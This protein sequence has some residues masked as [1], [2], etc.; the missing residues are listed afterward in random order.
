MG[1]GGGLA[2]NNL[3]RRWS[4]CAPFRWL[5]KAALDARLTLP[6][7]GTP[8][9]VPWPARPVGARPETLADSAAAWLTESPAAWPVIPFW[10]LLH[11]FAET[12]AESLDE[13]V[14]GRVPGA[15]ADRAACDALVRGYCA[16]LLPF[17]QHVVTRVVAAEI[18][19]ERAEL[20]TGLM[21]TVVGRFG[22]R[23]RCEEFLS[24]YRPLH[25]QVEHVLGA[26]NRSIAALIGHFRDDQAVIRH[27]LGGSPAELT[28]LVPTGDL[29]ER[30]AVTELGF[31][32][33][34]GL[35]HKPHSLALDERLTT[36]FEE[37]ARAE[38]DCAPR[39]PPT[40]DRDGYGWQRRV[41]WQ[42]VDSTEQAA[43][44][45]R[46]I[47]AMIALAY[48][49]RATD[50]H[51]ENVLCQGG[52]LFLLDTECFFGNTFSTMADGRY[53]AD[54]LRATVLAAC[55]LPQ[56]MRRPRLDRTG[57]DRAV[58]PSVLGWHDSSQAP[59][60][61]GSQRS[62]DQPYRPKLGDEWLTVRGHETAV[63]EGF[64]R[65]YR[66]LRHSRD[67][68]LAPDGPLTG[69]ADVRARHVVRG[70]SSYFH[71]LY[72]LGDLSVA[73]DPHAQ[74]ELVNTL[75]PLDGHD[76]E[77]S[78]RV[79]EHE[80]D[81]LL[82]GL[83]PTFT[84]T[85]GDRA[86]CLHRRIEDGDGEIRVANAYPVTSID[87]VRQRLT[88]LSEEDLV[89]Q[90]RLIR[91]ALDLAADDRGAA[92]RDRGYRPVL[93][94]AGPDHAELLAA[95]RGIAE[96]ISAGTVH[97][98]GQVW[99]P[100]C[101]DVGD[102]RR[103]LLPST[104]V[105]YH[106]AAGIALFAGFLDVLSGNR[107]AL[108]EQAERAMLDWADRLLDRFTAAQLARHAQLSVFEGIWGAIYAAACLGAARGDEALI[109][110][111]EHAVRATTEGI[112][113][114]TGWDVISGSAGIAAVASEL[115]GRLGMPGSREA[116]VCAL[117]VTGR[118][119][120]PVLEH[121]RI[122][123]GVAHGLSGAAMAFAR[124]AGAGLDPAGEDYRAVAELV[125]RAEQ[126]TF[127][128][129]HS[130]WPDSLGPDDADWQAGKREGWC[131]G[132]TGIG[133]V[134]TELADPPGIDV[135]HRLA[136]AR[137]L[138][139]H[140]AMG[141]E[142]GLCHGA[143]GAWELLSTLGAAET[144][145]ALGAILASGRT[146]GWVT[147]VAEGLPD[148]GLMTGLAGIGLGL[149]RAAEPD[150]TPRVLTL[151]LPNRSA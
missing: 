140:R 100:I 102:K 56:P 36:V 16:G 119:L 134:L 115:H 45:F 30:G 31:A 13:L 136:V 55:V 48:A 133:M 148:F 132:A 98:G 5:P 42:P 44:Y 38:P 20:D 25:R 93:V 106:G 59:G 43:G 72:R 76:D 116:A 66:W 26:H 120:E 144:G 14:R 22:E 80:R 1:G 65:T 146:T 108:A 32:D 101:A 130:G 47:G 57:A 49:L 17:V 86:L 117:A 105:L 110:W 67:R 2:V 84:L 123:T 145:P 52:E 75:W 121:Q 41:A 111:A 147:G 109:G 150:R 29:H 21:R 60:P 12:A 50:L 63:I 127:L 39:I 9:V 19:G 141:T 131:R 62:T 53:E 112:G 113:E 96:L 61:A 126:S 135:A 68:L 4:E 78:R 94:A 35:M 83:I 73:V 51:R 90:C 71:F 64:R 8:D 54:G 114:L 7:E 87:L 81:G 85:V 89:V 143:F 24:R 77:A 92:R 139:L 11:H 88:R 137:E 10:P 40:V 74:E 46:R 15:P 28:R 37:F 6:V 129:E 151:E 125:M 138:A 142:H 104:G 23:E 103:R 3:A 95:A 70:T 128:D 34:L 118:K 99:W 58:D 122:P 69:F 107:S 97:T 149:L 18:Q 33:A 91:Y 82:R 79:F 124:A 27:L